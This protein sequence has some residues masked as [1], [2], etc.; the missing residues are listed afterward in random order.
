M[1]GTKKVDRTVLAFG[2]ARASAPHWPLLCEDISRYKSWFLLPLTASD[3][4]W[5]SLNSYIANQAHGC[6][7]ESYSPAQVSSTVW[8]NK[9]G[10]VGVATSERDLGNSSIGDG[11]VRFWNRSAEV[12]LAVN[13]NVGKVARILRSIAAK[14]SVSHVLNKLVPSR[15]PLSC[16]AIALVVSHRLLHSA[17]VMRGTIVHGVARILNR[18][19]GSARLGSKQSAT[20][21]S[22]RFGESVEHTQGMLV[23]C[24]LQIVSTR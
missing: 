22:R 20:T 16:A 14:G 5:R 10:P 21:M 12:K 1:A 23:A 2:A 19:N 11:P 6:A 4:L 15:K 24:P 18:L 3:V 9:V 7:S 8:R 13:L 17:C